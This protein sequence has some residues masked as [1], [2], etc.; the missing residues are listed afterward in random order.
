M[1]YLASPA[2]AEVTGQTIGLGGDRLALWSYPDEVATAFADD[3]WSA[4]QIAAAYPHSLGTRT[5]SYGI[6]P[7][8][9]PAP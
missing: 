5:Q 4:D 1:V 7:P 6:A 9:E 2:S 8:K 3:G